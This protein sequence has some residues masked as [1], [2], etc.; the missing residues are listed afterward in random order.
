MVMNTP[1][2]ER[3]I[4]TEL[5]LATS[6]STPG[7][8]SRCTLTS[9]LRTPADKSSGLAVAWRITPTPIES[10]PFRRTLERS[11]TEACSTRA[12]SAIRMGCPFTV[13]ITT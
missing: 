5:S 3:S 7:G 2:I 9:S 12:T 8:R 4:K 1:L 10:R 11:S 13:R 6:T